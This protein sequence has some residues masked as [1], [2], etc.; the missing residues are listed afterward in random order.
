[1][2]N[3]GKTERNKKFILRYSAVMDAVAEVEDFE[4]VIRKYTD[5]ENF[6]RT[7]VMVRSAFPDYTLYIEDMTAE[8]D[9]VI[10]HGIVRG[11]HLGEIFG[12]PAT[13]KKVEFPIM[14]KYHVVNDMILNA[15]PMTDNLELFEQLGAINK[16]V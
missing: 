10:I 7:V 16:P 2:D 3:L 9:Y 14:V 8:D 11:T 6:I 4:D 15:W 12:V 13:S 5:N 1:M